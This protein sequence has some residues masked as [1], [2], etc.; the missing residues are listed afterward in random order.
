[1]ED[2]SDSVIPIFPK[3]NRAVFSNHKKYR[4]PHFVSHVADYAKETRLSL[5]SFGK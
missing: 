3:F 4:F 5:I 2:D 1:L